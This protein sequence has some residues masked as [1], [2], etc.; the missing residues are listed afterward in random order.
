MSV[1]ITQVTPYSPAAKAGIKAGDTLVSINGNPIGDVL[2]Y[3]F[4][5]TDTKLA[6]QL[7]DRKIKIKKGEYDDLG[8]EFET[9]LMDK[10]RS[11]RNKCVFCFIDQL[12]KGMRETLYFKDDDDRLSFLQGN[13]ITMTNL[14]QEEVNR[15]IKMKLKVNISVHTT[16]PELRNKMTGN[17]FA[18][19]CLKYLYQLAEAGNELNCQ[20]VLCPGWNDGEELRKTLSDLTALYPSVE[21]IACVPIGETKYRE[22]LADIPLFN[23]ETAGQVIDIIEEFGSKMEQEHGDRLVYPADEFFLIAERPMP[24]YEYYGD[25]DQYENGVGMWKSLEHEFM[26]GLEEKKEYDEVH[27]LVINR[28]IATGKLAAPLLEKLAQSVKKY[29]PNVNINVYP[30]RND[31]FGETITVAGLVTGQDI[32]KQLVP[33]KDKIGTELIIPNTMLRANSD[34]FLDDTTV[35]DVEKA[36]GVR[37]TPIVVDGYEL[38]ECMTKC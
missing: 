13:Y 15:I 22:G 5:A 12:P 25:F 9:Y 29:F 23:K 26:E 36:L 38:L 30:I 6:V 21:S 24:E 16:N 2:D 7:E 10:K 35:G 18:G 28:S 8:L 4:Y 1:K 32:I 34:V 27:N 14:T 20:L 19:D 37:V 17:R 3:Q 31:F 11:C 33:V